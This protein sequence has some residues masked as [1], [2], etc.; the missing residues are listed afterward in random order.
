M[1]H[2]LNRRSLVYSANM[3][4][5]GPRCHLTSSSSINLVTCR[6]A[7]H[8][9]CLIF[10]VFP[11]IICVSDHRI[12]T[13][14]IWHTFLSS[15]LPLA[16]CARTGLRLC[17][18]GLTQVIY[19]NEPIPIP[20]VTSHWC[21]YSI[22]VSSKQPR[23]RSNTYSALSPIEKWSGSKIW[24]WKVLC[25][26]LLVLAFFIPSAIGLNIGR[27]PYPESPSP[28]TW[29]QPIGTLRL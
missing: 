20:R 26:F 2:N 18:E 21:S 1:S 23:H 14:R 4:Y 3:E 16:Q 12:A 24:T 29:S 5:L 8:L 10:L 7:L 28:I 15:V 9:F 22:V 13:G 17:P 11:R 19:I 6:K 25:F 27:S